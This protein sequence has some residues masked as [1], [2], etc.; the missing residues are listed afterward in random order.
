MAKDKLKDEEKESVSSRGEQLKSTHS[1]L[2][3]EA[4]RMAN[5]YDE[6][7]AKFEK[8]NRNK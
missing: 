2:I 8:L 5:D 3:A 6:L 7:I 4:T 1:G